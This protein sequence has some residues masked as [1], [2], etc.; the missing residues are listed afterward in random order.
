MTEADR[1]MVYMNK[2]T[3]EK[4]FTVIALALALF[5][6]GMIGV[7]AE[8]EGFLRWIRMDDT[9]TAVVVSSGVEVL[10][11]G[12]FECICY[13]SYEEIPAGYRD[14]IWDQDTIPEDLSFECAEIY[15]NSTIIFIESFYSGN[16]MKNVLNISQKIFKDEIMSDV[17]FDSYDHTYTRT[18]NNTEIDFLRAMNE[19]EQYK[20]IA[21][22]NLNNVQYIIRSD[23]KPEEIEKLITAFLM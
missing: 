22:F 23:M 15:S 8:K 9:G 20:Y 3:K 4:R 18:V 7:Y 12:V 2:G 16:D 10:D 5:L 17:M 6:G 19:E 13:S 1:G 14:V 11:A 21:C